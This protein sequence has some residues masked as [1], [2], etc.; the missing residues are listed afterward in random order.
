MRQIPKERQEAIRS[1][2]VDSS[3]KGLLKFASVCKFFQF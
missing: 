2:L 3:V 1:G